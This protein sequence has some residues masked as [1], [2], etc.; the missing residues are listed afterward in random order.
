DRETT[1]VYL[2]ALVRLKHARAFGGSPGRRSVPRGLRHTGVGVDNS[3]SQAVFLLA[4]YRE[5]AKDVR[6]PAARDG[7]PEWEIASYGLRPA[8]TFIGVN[9][10]LR[11]RTPMA[12][13]TALEIAGGGRQAAGSPTP[14]GGS[15]G[16]LISSMWTSGTSGKRRIG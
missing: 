7:R 14:H 9:G 10:T 5:P 2:H 15:V 4:R 3:A 8:C 11:S 6:A 1:Q 16:R 12:S 13:N